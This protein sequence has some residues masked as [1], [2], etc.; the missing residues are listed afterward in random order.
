MKSALI[1]FLASASLTAF[2]AQ[3]I[4]FGEKSSAALMD[5]MSDLGFKGV[6]SPGGVRYG[7]VACRES[8]SDPGNHASRV[9]SCTISDAGTG[10]QS[11]ELS[12]KVS[13]RLMDRMADYGFVGQD[14]PGGYR[15]GFIKC[16][17]TYRDPGNHASRVASCVV[18]A[19]DLSSQID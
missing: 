6:D 13:A 9:V 10:G 4:A 5:K 7:T 18:T 14:S 2:A 1:L 3:P 16:S 15:D 8:Y 17:E 11:F 12:E 19:N